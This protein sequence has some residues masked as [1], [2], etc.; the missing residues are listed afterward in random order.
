MELKRLEAYAQAL[1]KT[2]VNLQKNQTLVISVD[3][4]NHE[5]VEIVTAE[6]YKLGAKE[7]VV[8]WRSTP[9]SKLR[10][11]HGAQEVLEQPAP[12]I[13]T[14][15]KTY[16]DEKAAFLSLISA[17]PTAMKGVPSD[18]MA[19]QSRALNKALSFYHD[20]IMDSTLTWCVASVAT[21]R[22]ANLLE[23]TGTDEEKVDALWSHLF[24]LCRIEGVSEE[25][26]LDKHLGR[27]KNRT[28]ALNEHQFTELHYTCSNGTDLI[29][30]LPKNHLWQGGAESS[31]SGVIFDANIPTEEVFSAPQF[32]NV[33]GKVYSTKPLIYQ[34][35]HID[36]FWFEFKNGKIVNYDAKEGKE[37][38]TK[39]IETDEGSSYL[40][41][42][43]LVD[44]YSPISQS[45]RI[46][47]ETLYDENAS[48]HLAI[49]AA[50][51]TCLKNSD[52]LNK[53]QLKEAGLNYSH[54]HVD[55]MIG[56]ENMNIVG[57]TPDGKKITVMEK[58]RL[59]I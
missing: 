26:S 4:E 12:W 45:N 6:A 13:P 21:L 27:L 10:L 50:Y 24:T 56:L 7:V 3:V 5:F 47:F 22:W 48:C 37:Y 43:A 1:L 2:G 57:T 16:V 46:Y 31:K 39:L 40:G 15:Y 17:N 54:S 34:G 35:N 14:Y 28:E 41:E 58:G 19:A 51:P 11:L 33:N 53:E 29:V 9:I 30:G 20:A 38:L 59:L 42:L 8:N 55:F 23:F 25:N 32:D 18:R 52:G 36:E 49:G 44:H